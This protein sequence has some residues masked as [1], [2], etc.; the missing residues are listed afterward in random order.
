MAKTLTAGKAVEFLAAKYPKIAHDAVGARFASEIRDIMWNF[1]PWKVSL[2]DLQP[3]ALVQNQADYGPPAYILPTDF[4]GLHDVWLRSFNDEFIPLS[5]SKEVPISATPLTPSTVAVT[6]NG[7]L[8]FHPRPVYYSPDWWFEGKYKKS[9]TSITPSNL[10]STV[11]PWDDMYFPVFRR[12][13]I[14]K[15]KD[16]FLSDP[17]AFQDF[18]QFRSMLQ[19]MANRES[20]QDGITTIHPSHGL[21]L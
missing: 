17:T 20:G 12:G 18:A 13:L 3:M 14:W 4:Y 9:T 16:E 2:G 5:V 6:E 11:L 10:N 19:E 15:F 7:Y 8:R 1:Y 21:A